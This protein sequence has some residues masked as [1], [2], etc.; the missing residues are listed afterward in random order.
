MI[1]FIEGTKLNK[2]R[3]LVLQ[4]NNLDLKLSQELQE[5]KVELEKEKEKSRAEINERETRERSLEVSKQQLETQLTEME[6]ENCELL[7][8]LSL[9]QVGTFVHNVPGFIEG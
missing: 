8:E 4:K 6:K 5:I 7:R 3:E 2:L 1:F 9:L